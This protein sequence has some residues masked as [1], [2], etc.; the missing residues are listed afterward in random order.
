MLCAG[1][2]AILYS[3]VGNK[4]FVSR[5]RVFYTHD[6]KLLTY[7][8]VFGGCCHHSATFLTQLMQLHM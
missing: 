7:D 2:C 4:Q 3:P 5:G 6:V 1:T 8:D